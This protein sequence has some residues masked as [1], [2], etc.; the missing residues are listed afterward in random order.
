MAES[1]EGEQRGEHIPA[2]LAQYLARRV[3]DTVP[4]SVAGTLVSLTEDE[5]K[6]LEKV[7]RSLQDDKAEPHHYVFV[8]H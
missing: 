5:V 7:G 3:L 2:Y 6:A 8:I 1:Y 4:E